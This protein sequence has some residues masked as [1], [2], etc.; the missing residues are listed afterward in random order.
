MFRAVRVRIFA[1]SAVLPYC[2]VLVR[3]LLGSSFL[4]FLVFYHL[5][6]CWIS[7]PHSRDFSFF[8]LI[9]FTCVP[10]FARFLVGFDSITF[11]GFVACVS[12]LYISL[13]ALD[14]LFLRFSRL[15]CFLPLGVGTYSFL[16]FPHLAPSP[17]ALTV[18]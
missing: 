10:F 12:P 6:F 3:F 18:H 4:S 11:L 14:F 16:L 1:L 5:G 7:V 13:F 9:S 2:C 17:A 8:Y 15:S